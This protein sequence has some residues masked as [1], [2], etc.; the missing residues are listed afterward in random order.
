MTACVLEHEPRAEAVPGLLL[1][2]KHRRD[3]DDFTTEIGLLIVDTCRIRDGGAPSEATPKTRHLKQPEAPAPGDLSIMALYDSRTTTT[4]IAETPENPGGDQSE[5]MVPVLHVVASWLLLVAEERPLSAELPRSVL[6]QLVILER[7]HDWL[8]AESYADDYWR[9]MRE[10]RQHLRGAVRDH[11]HTRI[12]TC[13]LPTEESEQCG[14][15]ILVRNGDTV[16]RCQRCG[17][18]WVTDQQQARWSVRSA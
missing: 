17:A 11:T 8:A 18:E 12:G 2:G 1:C 13:D 15:S 6:G 3:L 5:P 4:R 10:L 7:H 14:G 16:W 9:E